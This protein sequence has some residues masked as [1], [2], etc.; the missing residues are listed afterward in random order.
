MWK[1]KIKMKSIKSSIKETC[2]VEEFQN[3][4]KEAGFT[5]AE[6]EL[7]ESDLVKLRGKSIKI[8]TDKHG[9]VKSYAISNP[10]Q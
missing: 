2:S 3:I 10:D 4:L 7:I 1:W 8:N 9:V 6:P 5:H